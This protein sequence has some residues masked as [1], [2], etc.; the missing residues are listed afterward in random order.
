LTT[1]GLL[2]RFQQGDRRACGQVISLIES[3]EEHAQE[4]LHRLYPRTG[5]AYRI[6]VTGPPG[7][8]KSS[9]VEKLALACREERMS[10][11]IVAVDPTSPFSGG[12]L[13]GDRIRM[14]SLFL[15]PEVFI[16]SMASRGSFGGLALKTREVCDALDAFGKNVI[17]I[18]TIGVGQVELDVASAAD[19]TVVVLMPESGDAIQAMKAGLMEVGDLFVINKADREGADRMA[20]AVEAILELHTPDNGWRP[21]LVKT[22]AT[23]GVGVAD[24]LNRIWNHRAYLVQTQG[25]EQRRRETARQ[26][27]VELVESRLHRRLW[28]DDS[29]RAAM[30]DWLGR[31]ARRDA[32]PYEAAQAILNTGQ[33]PPMDADGHR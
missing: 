4:L 15:D 1:D 2:E 30:N 25:L 22:V 7:A 5:N 3:D 33:K 26:A 12:A 11:G 23:Q 21:S 18:E 16:R 17:L 10:V 6:G 19:T 31:V 20:Q 28:Q 32:T 24:L 8:G 29:V 14:S 27:I 13:L 9:L